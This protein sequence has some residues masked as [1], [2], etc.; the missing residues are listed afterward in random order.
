MSKTIFDMTLDELEKVH[1]IISK[2]N[3]P[4]NNAKKKIINKLIN[5]KFNEFKKENEKLDDIINKIIM[6]TD[7]KKSD[8]NE[9]NKIRGN[10]EKVWGNKKMDPKFKNEIEYDYKNNK[11]MERLN[12]ELDFRIHGEYK[13]RIAKPYDDTNN[14]ENTD[15]QNNITIFNSE[16]KKIKKR[17][18]PSRL[19]D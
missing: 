8:N 18:L 4:E 17:L 11:L 16:N 13:K 19:H 3:D 10:M 7:T 9:I 5:N 2:Y 6:N 15:E 1:K 12:N 14:Y